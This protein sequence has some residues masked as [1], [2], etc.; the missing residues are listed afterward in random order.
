MVLPS[1]DRV[2]FV[3]RPRESDLWTNDAR[4]NEQSYEL[5]AWH[6]KSEAGNAGPTLRC[7][8]GPDV[9]SDRLD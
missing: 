6:E 9:R 8:A 4:L 3:L 7:V 5:G 2:R 1:L